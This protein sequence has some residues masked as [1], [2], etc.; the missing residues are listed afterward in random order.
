M[1]PQ[2]VARPKRNRVG[3]NR[4][5]FESPASFHFQGKNRG[6]PP[7]PIGSLAFIGETTTLVH[8]K[9]RVGA[10]QLGPN[11]KIYGVKVMQPTLLEIANPDSPAPQFNVDAVKAGGGTLKLNRNAILGLPTFTRITRD[12]DDRCSFIAGEVEA[13][14]NEGLSGLHNSMAPCRDRPGP[15]GE[16]TEPHDHGATATKDIGPGGTPAHACRPLEIRPLRP[17]VAIRW[18][19]SRCDCIEGDDTEIMHLTICNPYSNVTLSASSFTSSVWSTPATSRFRSFPTARRRSSSCPSVPIASTT[20]TLRLRHPRVRPQAARRARRTLPD[21]C[22][23]N[24]LRRLL[25]RR[26]GSVLHLRGVSRLRAILTAAR[27][28]T[29]SRLIADTWLCGR[30]IRPTPRPVSG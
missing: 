14:L 10:L 7:F 29:A 24:L 16:S 17:S 18:G 12:C 27:L 4:Q 2:G 20:S 26:R 8:S 28:T 23:R 5:V 3:K 21:S 30:P 6:F 22:A 15:Q 11:G 9:Y 13:Q 1:A 25:P 19:S